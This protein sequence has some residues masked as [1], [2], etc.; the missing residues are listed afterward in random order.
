MMRGPGGYPGSKKIIFRS[1]GTERIIIII[2]YV[3]GLVSEGERIEEFM[4]RS[5]PQTVLLHIS[6]EEMEGLIEYADGKVRVGDPESVSDSVYFAVL[7]QYGK[8]SFPSP[9]L[10]SAVRYARRKNIPLEALDMTEEMFTEVYLKHVGY[11]AHLRKERRMRRILR[12]ALP[13]ED[14]VEALL[15]IDREIMRQRGYKEV[16]R[17]RVAWQVDRTLEYMS[18]LDKAVLLQEVER[19]DEMIS[20]LLKRLR[21]SGIKPRV[22]L[23]PPPYPLQKE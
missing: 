10:T 14:P 22:T 3:K 2:P 9:A 15:L 17:A 16:E 19:V 4:R 13:G 12:M 23:I 1:G 21:S 7:S 20:M 18:R 8:V 6:P 5:L 11:L